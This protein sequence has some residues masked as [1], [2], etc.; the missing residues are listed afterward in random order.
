MRR[1]DE[2]SA[3][4]R[5]LLIDSLPQRLTPPQPKPSQRPTPEPSAVEPVMHPD[6]PEPVL[7]DNCGRRYCKGRCGPD[8]NPTP[9]WERW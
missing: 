8:A 6:D 3:F 1:H 7:C 5:T 9:R 2:L 4:A